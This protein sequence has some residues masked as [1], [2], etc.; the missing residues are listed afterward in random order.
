[1]V[2]ADEVEDVVA[3]DED[4]EVGVDE[5]AEGDGVEVSSW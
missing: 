3:E 2:V 4:V 1:M 5:V